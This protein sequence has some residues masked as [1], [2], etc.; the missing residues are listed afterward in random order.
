[1]KLTSEMKEIALQVFD[2][3]CQP[4][5]DKDA[6]ER[7]NIMYFAERF[8]AALLKPESSAA[9]E[10]LEE[11]ESLRKDAERYRWLNGF[12]MDNG[13]FPTYPMIDPRTDMHKLDA[14]ID[15]Y[16][17]NQVYSIADERDR[18]M[19]VGRFAAALKQEK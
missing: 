12:V 2:E 16:I 18:M 4:I 9:L 13:Q 17:E 7:Y 19:K 5:D 1:M 11:L 10:A 6:V 14:D 15:F 8:L 3:I